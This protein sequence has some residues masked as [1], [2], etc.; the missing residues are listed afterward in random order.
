MRIGRI[1]GQPRARCAAS[2]GRAT[3]SSTSTRA[4]GARARASRGGRRSRLDGRPRTASAASTCRERE[5]LRIAV[6]ADFDGPHARSWLRWFIA[7][8]HDVH[9]ISFYP[10][11]DAARGRDHARAA[12]P[13]TGDSRGRAPCSDAA[14]LDDPRTRAARHHAA[15]ARRCAIG[16]PGCARVL[17]EIA[18]DVFHA[19]FRRRA[20]VLRRAR[21]RA[22]VRRDGVGLRRARRAA[23]R[24]GVAAH[25]AMDV[26]AAPTS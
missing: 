5:R 11:R 9:A 14:R 2:R 21:R 12:P 16:A 10:P 1:S 22:P 25:R 24:S 13:R 20:R 7:R 8:G 26:C 19:H 3:R 18:P 17:R 6:L 15:G 23:T 4:R